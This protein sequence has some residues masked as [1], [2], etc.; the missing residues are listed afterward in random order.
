MI[1]ELLNFRHDSDTI[2]TAMGLNKEIDDKCRE[3]VHFS[4]FTNF[5][6]KEDF[7]SD[8]DNN[9]PENLTTVTGVLEK[10]LGLC[11]SKEEEIYTLFV[12]KDV[13]NHCTQALS[14]YQVF[15]GE[16]DEKVKKKLKMLMELVELKA[17]A[18]DEDDRKDVITPKDMFKKITIAKDNMYNF[19]NYYKALKNESSS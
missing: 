9:T 18:D 2:P 6:I 10:A 14:A 8:D 4:S 7:F 19:D 3:I 17:M 15:E 5:F 12:F 1:K 13:H 11:K 16:K